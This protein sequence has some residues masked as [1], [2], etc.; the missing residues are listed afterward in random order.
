MGGGGREKSVA[1]TLLQSAKTDRLRIKKNETTFKNIS[2][3]PLELLTETTRNEEGVQYRV[4]EV[5]SRRI[6]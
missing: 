5:F 1:E 3:S 2:N 6:T 4:G